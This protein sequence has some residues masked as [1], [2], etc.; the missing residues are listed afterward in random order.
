MSKIKR[1]KLP[2][3]LEEI[4]DN[5]FPYKGE[6]YRE[7]GHS[8]NIE[9]KKVYRGYILIKPTVG[10]RF[11]CGSLDTNVVKEILEETEEGGKFLTRSD[12]IYVWKITEIL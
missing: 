9:N 11:R 8:P 10:W 12:S 1:D 4:I 6:C 5:N 2:V 3:S 7:E